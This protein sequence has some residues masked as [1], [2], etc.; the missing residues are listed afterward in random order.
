M[1]TIHHSNR[2]EALA[3]ELARVTREP[4]ASPF[5][6]EIVVVQSRGVARWLSL[7]LAD[8]TGVCA[9]VRFPFPGA[10]AWEL[11][12]AVCT[13]VPEQSAFDPEVLTWRILAALPEL[14]SSSA[15]APVAAYVRG[16]HL[17]RY[18]LSARLAQ[19]YDEYLVYRPDWIAAWESNKPPHWQAALWQRLA[20]D[21]GTRHRAALQ[22]ELVRALASAKAPAALPERVSI[23]GA[24]ALPPALIELFTALARAS[25]V[26]V[27]VPNPCREYWGD[28]RE[29]GDIARKALAGKAEAPYLETG[30]SLLA[31]LGKQ[32]RDFI[33]L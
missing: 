8:R 17:R 1:L 3:D 18:E 4:L 31:S 25:D 20:K 14:E 32:G 33:D 30:N 28:I 12:G 16:D 22:A 15:F 9:N 11:Y 13:D 5:A 10:Y 29:E 24:P 21:A 23:F 27:F 26:H 19:L 6:P 7:R 2:L